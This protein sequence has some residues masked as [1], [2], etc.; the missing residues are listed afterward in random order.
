MKKA[1]KYPIPK[2]SAKFS[3]MLPIGFKFLRVNPQGEELM[4]WAEVKDVASTQVDFQVF[5]TGH[6]IPDEAKYLTTYDDGPFVFHL[7]QLN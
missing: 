6:E 5:G 4:L 1:F 2:R 3:L 7:Y